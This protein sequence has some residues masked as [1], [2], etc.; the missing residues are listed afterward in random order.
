M[1]NKTYPPGPMLEFINSA[2]PHVGLLSIKISE[3]MSAVITSCTR[4][5]GYAADHDKIDREVVEDVADGTMLVAVI[6]HAAAGAALHGKRFSPSE[7]G[8]FAER[9]A[10][11]MIPDFA[12]VDKEIAAQQAAKD[13]TETATPKE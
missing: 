9:I 2:P 8:R 4:M 5:E 3:M 12:E 10:R 11:E 13:A 1:D 7:F 6:A